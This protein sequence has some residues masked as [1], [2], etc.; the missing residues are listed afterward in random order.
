MEAVVFDM[1]G[2]I[3]D[4]EQLVLDSWETVA[5]KYE[6]SD[7]K[8]VMLRCVGTNRDKT[9][10]IVLDAYGKDFPYEKFRAEA[11]AQYQ[12]FMDQGKLTLKPG[13]HDLLDYLKDRRI[14]MAVAS[15]TRR[16]MVKKEL[17]YAGVIDS[18]QVIYGGDNVRNS[19]P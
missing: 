15:S 18:F 16:E 19:K 1:D 17:T 14:P 4:S 8:P 3:F 12:R 2:V 5:G 7:I 9:K 10:E 13:L 6:I 11:S